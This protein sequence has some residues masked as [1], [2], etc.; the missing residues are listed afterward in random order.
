MILR[1]VKVLH[2]L[3]VIMKKV[4]YDV[5]ILFLSILDRKECLFLIIVSDCSLPGNAYLS[6]GEVYV[7]TEDSRGAVPLLSAPGSR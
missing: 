7:L 2:V 5:V 3:H 6:S 1:R 4:D